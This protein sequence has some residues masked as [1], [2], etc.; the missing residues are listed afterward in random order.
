MTREKVEAELIIATRKALRSAQ[1]IERSLQDAVDGFEDQFDRAIRDIRDLEIDVAANVRAAERSIDALDGTS[2]TL[3]ALAD[4]D[5]AV[6]DFDGI[7]P[8]EVELIGRAEL[9]DA[10]SAI[11]G[12]PDEEVG[13]YGLAELGDALA[14]IDGVPDEDIRIY[15][16]PDLADAVAAIDAIPDE[17]VII[18][19]RLDIDQG[20]INTL[21]DVGQDAGQDLGD[22]ISEGVGIGLLAGGARF[23]PQAAL[24]GAAAIAVNDVTQRASDLGESQSKN[25]QLFAEYVDLVNDF[26]ADA[27]NTVGLSERQAL[28]AIGSFGALAV[29]MQAPRD[30]AALLSNDLTVLAA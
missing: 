9:N 14:A 17:E 24:L 28:D 21:N 19:G 1:E 4:T 13:F 25:N 3:L 26:A 10:L 20:D 18:R 11:D 7:T 5:E 12:V 29:G 23:L 22:G 16:V 8:E 6:A 30:E 2:V 27:P 15:G